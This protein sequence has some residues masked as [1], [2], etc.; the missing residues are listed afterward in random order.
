ME[1][2]RVMVWN[3]SEFIKI[4]SI[5]LDAEYPRFEGDSVRFLGA[6]GILT[7]F[8]RISMKVASF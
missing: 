6:P 5:Y 2:L 8:S 3:I 7:C 4:I 1:I